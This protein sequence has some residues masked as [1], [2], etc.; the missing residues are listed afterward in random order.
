MATA[1]VVCWCTSTGDSHHLVVLEVLEEELCD[2]NRTFI[3][4]FLVQRF[5]SKSTVIRNLRRSQRYLTLRDRILGEWRAPVASPPLRSSYCCRSFGASS[6]VG[7]IFDSVP[8]PL[9]MYGSFTLAC[10]AGCRRCRRLAFSCWHLAGC[11]TVCP[12][13]HSVG[14]IPFVSSVFP[15]AWF[16]SPFF[17]FSDAALHA[18]DP[19]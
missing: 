11:V 2:P 9:W 13:C 1:V 14:R 3:N 5:N 17:R 4:Q 6:V 18:H 12:R 7:F 15:W 19:V 10:F 8:V 16:A